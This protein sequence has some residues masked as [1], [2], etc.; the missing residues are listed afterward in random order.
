MG[1][2]ADSV[3]RVVETPTPTPTGDIF[4]WISALNAVFG[5]QVTGSVL[6][7]PT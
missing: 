3:E 1:R 4:E 5:F 6:M 7:H 2:A